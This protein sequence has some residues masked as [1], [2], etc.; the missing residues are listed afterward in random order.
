MSANK[1]TED[2]KAQYWHDKLETTGAHTIC[3]TLRRIYDI[4]KD[5]DIES[6]KK[7]KL[8]DLIKEATVYGKRM[9]GKLRSYK[10]DYFPDIY[11]NIEDE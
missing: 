4:I 6:T 7:D 1:P 2:E 3:E 8:V 10:P 11:P 5:L 9:D